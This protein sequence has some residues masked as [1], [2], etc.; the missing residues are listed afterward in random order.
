MGLIDEHLRTDVAAGDG[1]PGSGKP[2]PA[3]DMQASNLKVNA[4]GDV[5]S[6][7]YLAPDAIVPN[8]PEGRD[9]LAASARFAV[10]PVGGSDGQALIKTPTGLAWGDAGYDGGSF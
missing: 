5:L 4:I 2:G 3:D 7:G 9:A 6:V 1:A 8:T 10:L